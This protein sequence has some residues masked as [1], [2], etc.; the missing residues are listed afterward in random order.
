LAEIADPR[1]I[2][3][4]LCG[5]T[6]DPWRR[7]VDPGD[8]ATPPR[9]TDWR[10]PLTNSPLR[11]P[12]PFSPTRGTHHS[13]LSSLVVAILH[14]RQTPHKPMCAS[15][16]AVVGWGYVRRALVYPLLPSRLPRSP[17]QRKRL[18]TNT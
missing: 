7:H 12:P 9:F 18:T 1:P 8:T 17:P 5:P 6:V 10:G 11:V 4:P 16:V 3:P 13:D 14:G 15:N 2:F